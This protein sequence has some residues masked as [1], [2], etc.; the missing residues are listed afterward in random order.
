MLEEFS[1]ATLP[2]D[3]QPFSGDEVGQARKQVLINPLR[4][5]ADIL[6]D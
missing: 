1:P 4:S 5:R 3:F 6:A 2:A